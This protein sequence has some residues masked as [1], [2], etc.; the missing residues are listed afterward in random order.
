M[1]IEKIKSLLHDQINIIHLE[2]KDESHKH[3]NHKQSNGGHFAIIIISNDFMN[4]SL[5]NRHKMVYNALD[6][7]IKKEI[8]AISISARTAVE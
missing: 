8:H 7:P 4:V 6:T 1:L 5:I 3:A 2:I